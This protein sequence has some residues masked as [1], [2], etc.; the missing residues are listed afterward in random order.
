MILY[1]HPAS[2]NCYKVRLL[3]SHLGRPFE[4]V[5]LSVEESHDKRPAEFL[6]MTAVRRIPMLVLPD[7]EPLAES[8]AILTYLAEG[9]HYFP[10]D[11]LARARVLA[12]MFFEQNNHEPNIATARYWRFLAKKPEERANVLPLWDEMGRRAL[13]A[14]ERHLGQNDFFGGDRYTI[15]DIALYGYT[16]VADEG[17]FELGPYPAIRAWLNRVREQPG[18]VPM[19]PE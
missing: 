9:T 3:L 12:W 6:E 17:G 1:Q 2:G 16:H 5:D 11:R 14:M 8:N 18:H 7:G 13:D 19:M 15:A 10:E 4:T